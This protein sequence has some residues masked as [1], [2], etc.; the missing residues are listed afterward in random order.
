MNAHVLI[1]M[2]HILFVGPLF[3]YVAFMRAGTPEAVY[4][5]L[6]GLGLVVLL[7]HGHKSAVRYMAGSSYLWVNAIHFLLIAPLMIYI[8]YHGK[9]TPRPAYELLAITAFGALGYHMYSILMQLQV[10]SD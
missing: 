6:F 2:F 7:Y 10:I 1:S 4:W 5:T 8:G 9:K 3:L